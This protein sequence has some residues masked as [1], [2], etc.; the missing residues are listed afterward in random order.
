[1]LIIFDQI[2]EFSMR[3]YR[4]TNGKKNFWNRMIII[5]WEIKSKWT[6]GRTDGRKKGRWFSLFS[7][8]TKH[9]YG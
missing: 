2:K 6:D 4:S 7:Q 1:M 8:W 5:R 9:L 3:K